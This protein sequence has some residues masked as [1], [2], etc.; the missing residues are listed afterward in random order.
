[1]LDT[2]KEEEMEKR[3]LG[4]T[5]EEQMALKRINKDQAKFI[6]NLW[7]V[8]FGLMAIIVILILC[9][10]FSGSNCEAAEAEDMVLYL[11]LQTIRDAIEMRDDLR[12][13]EAYTRGTYIGLLKH[14]KKGEPWMEETADCM[15]DQAGRFFGDLCSE[16]LTQ[17]RE[18]LLEDPVLLDQ[19]IINFTT[20]SLYQRCNYT[21]R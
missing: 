15:G 5:P 8:V 4:L 7:Y 6:Y 18:A 19:I 3:F 21:G 16:K 17:L 13:R 2:K 1:L 10:F 20:E 14:F 12:L 9:L 11:E